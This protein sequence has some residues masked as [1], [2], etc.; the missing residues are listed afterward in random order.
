M[1][2]LKNRFP[3]KGKFLTGLCGCN[4]FRFERLA[5]P[6][7]NIPFGLARYPCRNP[8][9]APERQNRRMIWLHGKAG[10]EC[11]PSEFLVVVVAAEI[12]LADAAVTVGAHDQKIEKPS[13]FDK[14]VQDIAAFP[15]AAVAL[16]PLVMLAFCNFD[17]RFIGRGFC[18]RRLHTVRPMQ[19]TP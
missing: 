17:D 3:T 9:P 18:F 16:P 4:K 19:R 14:V 12:S 10:P 15:P 5:F 8:R 1:S 6:A 11:S 13:A 2:G 7:T